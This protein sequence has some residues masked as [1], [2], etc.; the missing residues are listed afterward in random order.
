MPAQD[1]WPALAAAPLEF[2]APAALAAALDG[3]L[4]EPEVAELLAL[5]R[6]RARLLALLQEFHGLAPLA[7]VLAEGAPELEIIL[8][9]PQDLARLPQVCGALWHALAL[10][11]EIR[12]EAVQQLRQQLGAEV[13]DFAVSQRER[14]AAT[15]YLLEGERLRAAI[16][17][18]GQACVVA[19]LQTRP[20]P[21]RRWL[22]LRWPA[23][24][25]ATEG[26]LAARL[27]CLERALHW[28]HEGR[29][30]S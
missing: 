6:F 3:A 14:S 29:V 5:P 4:A 27:A 16:E 7:E 2:V 28:L 12:R 15:D 24:T 8:L 22:A 9:A 23:W 17:H 11:R 25:G 21:L 10:S 19:W 18:D 20:E 26:D 30:A 13:F 1:A